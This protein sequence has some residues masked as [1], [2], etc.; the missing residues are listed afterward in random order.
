MD[1]QLF[2]AMCVEIRNFR[3]NILR[4]EEG[5][6]SGGEVI[7]IAGVKSGLSLLGERVKKL[8]LIVAH[9]SNIIVINYQPR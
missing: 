8:F 7:F 9:N 2:A 3:A 4:A 5:G 6:A 1:V